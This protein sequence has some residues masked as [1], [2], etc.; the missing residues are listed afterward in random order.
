MSL[1]SKYAPPCD[2]CGAPSF[3]ALSWGIRCYAH[4]SP[5]LRS[6]NPN[7]NQSLPSGLAEQKP[8]DGH[9]IKD[10]DRGT[11]CMGPSGQP[12]WA[13]S[14]DAADARLPSVVV[15]IAGSWGDDGTW[16]ARSLPLDLTQ[17]T[18]AAFEASFELYRRGAR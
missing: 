17:V 1:V 14:P 10:D 8:D 18:P 16:P 7:A 5:E 12:E 9:T 15:D 4:L 6:A 2:I 13:N 11:P 3:A